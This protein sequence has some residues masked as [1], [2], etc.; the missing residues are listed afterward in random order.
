MNLDHQTRS[1]RRA[2]VLPRLLRGVVSSTAGAFVLVTGLL[3]VARTS[4]FEP[5]APL[6]PRGPLAGYGPFDLD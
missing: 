3:L 6:A 4:A 5:L 1:N 2:A